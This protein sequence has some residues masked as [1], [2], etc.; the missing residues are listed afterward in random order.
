MTSINTI[1]CDI[2]IVGASA[3]GTAAALAAAE[4]GATVCLT[5]ET[6]WL[7]GQLTVQGV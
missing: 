6:D 2:L 5:E 1:N 3:G 7:G 4:A